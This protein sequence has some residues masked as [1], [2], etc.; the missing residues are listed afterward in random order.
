MVG[1]L[2]LGRQNC[3]VFFGGKKIW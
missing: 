2:V 1:I 3:I